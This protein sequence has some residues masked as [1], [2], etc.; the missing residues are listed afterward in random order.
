MAF[1]QPLR[2]D[3]AGGRAAGI[4]KGRGMQFQ[5]LRERCRVDQAL[6][7]EQKREVGVDDCCFGRD[8]PG[9][10][11]WVGLIRGERREA[12]CVARARTGQLAFSC[13]SSNAFLCVSSCAC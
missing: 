1:F 10:G 4:G 5:R 13:D 8:G 9:K 7:E 6:G 12:A 3:F 11:I 2:R